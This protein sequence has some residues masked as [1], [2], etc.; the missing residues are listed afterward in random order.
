MARI[1]TPA[2]VGAGR[3]VSVLELQNW[4]VGY[5]R[6][7]ASL[8]QRCTS[9]RVF[10]LQLCRRFARFLAVL[11]ELVELRKQELARAH[12]RIGLEAG[13]EVGIEEERNG[14]AADAG[15]VDHPMRRRTERPA[16]DLG[17][18]VADI[19]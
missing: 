1:K 4:L 16:R 13:V 8:L 10:E 7:V 5:P 11:V 2:A 6:S 9:S 12:L 3:E 15:A 17:E 19:D 14:I 18:H